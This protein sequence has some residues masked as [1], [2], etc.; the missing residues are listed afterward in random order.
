MTCNNQHQ[1]GPVEPSPLKLGPRFEP[2]ADPP[3]QGAVVRFWY[4][5]RAPLHG[6]VK[7]QVC[8]DTEQHHRPCLGLLLYYH[9]GHMESIG[10]VRWDRDLSQE[11]WTPIYVQTGVVDEYEYMKDF[12]SGGPS[13]ESDAE[14][15][16]WQKIPEH[17]TIVWWFTSRLDR[18]IMY[19]D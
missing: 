3:G 5:T 1:V 14:R 9:D 15:D 4:M 16:G 19:D 17:G 10:Q 12:R 8:R 11:L 18:L 6:L 7:V 13:T 2:P